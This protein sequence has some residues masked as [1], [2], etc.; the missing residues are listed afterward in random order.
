MSCGP[1]VRLG[2]ES[3]FGHRLYRPALPSY[4]TLGLAFRLALL[5]QALFFRE[6]KH[7]YSFVSPRDKGSVYMSTTFSPRLRSFRFTRDH[8]NMPVSSPLAEQPCARTAVH[9]PRGASHEQPSES[10]PASTRK[11]RRQRGSVPASDEGSVKRTRPT[12]SIKTVHPG[13][14]VQP[15][16]VSG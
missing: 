9:R 13:L 16:S 10:W 15:F 1:F 14:T 11:L 3:H 5:F 4:G 2:S 7:F 6:A 8:V 12:G